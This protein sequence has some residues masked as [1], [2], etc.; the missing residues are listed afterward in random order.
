MLQFIFKLQWNRDALFLILQNISPDISK[1][2]GYFRVNKVATRARSMRIRG[3]GVENGGGTS[4]HAIPSI[5]TQTLA[6]RMACALHAVGEQP[7]RS[8]VVEKHHEKVCV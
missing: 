2:A 1:F 6:F 4:T 3:G 7:R 8:L 5:Y